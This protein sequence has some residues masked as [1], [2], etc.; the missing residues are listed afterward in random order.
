MRKTFYRPLRTDHCDGRRFFNPEGLEPPNLRRILEWRLYGKP[1]LWPERF[2]SPYPRDVPPE[3]VEG[4]RL[5]LS[6]IG[7][8]GFLLQTAGVNI[9][10]DPIWSERCSPFSFLGPRRRAEPGIDFD[11]L[12]AIDV[13]CVTHSHYDHMDRPTLMRLNERFRPRFVVPLGLER[14][15][16][17]WSRTTDAEGFDW[18]ER[19]A[20]AD[21]LAV[22]FWPTH[23]WSARGIHDRRRTLWTSFAFE[24]PAG[25]YYHV[26]DTGFDGGR[27]YA[28]AR[29][30]FGPARLAVLP[31]GA[32]EPR[33]VM[34]GQHQDPD[35]AVLG[36]EI[37]GA[38]RAVGSHWGYF[39]L[40]DEAIDDPPR[41]LAQALRDRGHPLERFIAA[42]PG[43]VHELAPHET[44]SPPI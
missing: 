16:K 1:V 23:H 38:E 3:R 43:F 17:R 11:D 30:A 15:L 39:R 6:H 31:I 5:R 8:A 33:F 9:L 27:R 42:R 2:E 26:G 36:M 4:R 40:T 12:P 19:L 28:S 41:R 37:L 20:L 32:Y 35:E 21:G 24:T 7:H 14:I 34:Q 22:T 44:R 29:E 13:V 18:H 25:F 10:I